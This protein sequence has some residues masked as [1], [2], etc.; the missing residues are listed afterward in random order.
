MDLIRKTGLIT[1]ISLC[2]VAG[3]F[4]L[5]EIATNGTGQGFEMASALCGG[6]L[7]FAAPYAIIPAHSEKVPGKLE[8]LGESCASGFYAIVLIAITFLG[9][10][11]LQ[12][13]VQSSDAGSGVLTLAGS[14]VFCAG[15]AFS[16]LVHLTGTFTALKKFSIS[17]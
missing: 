13:I 10:P 6:A 4:A 5:Y 16:L 8:L 9:L 12:S 1:A 14:L 17:A 2:V 3:L 7:F 15:F 11:Y